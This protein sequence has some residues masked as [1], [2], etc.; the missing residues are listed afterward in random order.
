LGGKCSAV[1]KRVGPT[2][3]T[4]PQLIRGP[5]R[6]GFGLYQDFYVYSRCVFF[7]WAD[8][9]GIKTFLIFRPP[10]KNYAPGV[11]SRINPGTILAIL[12][13]L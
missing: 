5:F 6:K 13:M 3:V 4:Q 8:T 11:I 2:I 12:V 10:A 1:K 9:P 7:R